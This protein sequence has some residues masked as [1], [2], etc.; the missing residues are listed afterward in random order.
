MPCTG[1]NLVVDAANGGG[2]AAPRG[3]AAL[4]AAGLPGHHDLVTWKLVLGGAVI[5]ALAAGWFVLSRWDMGTQVM[6]A[7]G[8]ALGVAFALLVVVSVIGAVLGRDKR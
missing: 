4:I 2:R 8:E 6:D 3:M 7:L 5:L 1:P